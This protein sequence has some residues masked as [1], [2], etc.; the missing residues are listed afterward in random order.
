MTSAEAARAFDGLYD[1]AAAHLAFVDL[2]TVAV[3]ATVIPL[4]VF[5]FSPSKAVLVA[6]S[7][8]VL[9]LILAAL[10]VPA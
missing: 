10:G 5:V 9:F 2:W 4:V 1:W 3:A 6:A 7:C 8:L